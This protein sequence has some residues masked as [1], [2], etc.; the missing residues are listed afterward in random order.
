MA[1]VFISLAWILKNPSERAKTFVEDGLGAVKLM[2]AHQERAIAEASDPAEIG[3]MQQMIE[4]WREWLASQR[5]DVFV[6]VRHRACRR[7]REVFRKRAPS[8]P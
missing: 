4:I 3:Q 6:E 1:D 8:V 7:I 2:I 5:L